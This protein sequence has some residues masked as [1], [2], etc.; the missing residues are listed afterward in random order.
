[1]R[2]QSS[3]ALVGPGGL[4]ASQLT[5]GVTISFSLNIAWS[6]RTSANA[7][8]ASVLVPQFSR[9]FSSR[10]WFANWARGHPIVPAPV[11]WGSRTALGWIES[12]ARQSPRIWRHE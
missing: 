9:H 6:N 5:M 7:S 2:H 4:Q 10:I 1:L 8:S 11:G 12:P 3:P